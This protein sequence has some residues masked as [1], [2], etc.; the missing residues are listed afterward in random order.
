[1]K[2]KTTVEYS[3]EWS[4]HSVLRDN[5]QALFPTIMNCL[6]H[7]I[8][9]AIE[10]LLGGI[11]ELF[12]AGANLE[13]INSND[14]GILQVWKIL[15][16]DENLLDFTFLVNPKLRNSSATY[17]NKL[18]SSF[19]VTNSFPFFLHVYQQV[20]RIYEEISNNIGKLS[21][22]LCDLFFNTFQ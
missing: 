10:P 4:L 2:Q 7:S 3:C 9:K 14:K 13:L 16:R 5:H 8:D 11:L 22:L 15:S 12:D 21:C 19:R 20:T 18:T 17:L 6:S 1:M